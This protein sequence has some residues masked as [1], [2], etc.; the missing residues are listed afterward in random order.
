VNI[1]YEIDFR[2]LT[3]QQL[4]GVIAVKSW[5]ESVSCNYSLILRAFANCLFF[6]HESVFYSEKYT[7]DCTALVDVGRVKTTWPKEL[8]QYDVHKPNLASLCIIFI[9]E[10]SIR[11]VL[12]P[13]N[14][15]HK[16]WTEIQFVYTNLSKC[17]RFLIKLPIDKDRIAWREI[18]IT[19]KNVCWKTPDWDLSMKLPNVK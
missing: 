17:V 19:Q 1:E 15:K 7:T 11:L 12:F 16:R 13:N 3:S 6:K 18:S 5:N 4:I 10:Y 9:L 8:N 2:K 14:C